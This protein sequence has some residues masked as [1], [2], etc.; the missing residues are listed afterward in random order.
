MIMD[1]ISKIID[2]IRADSDAEAEA[3]L[4]EGKARAAAITE[5]FA[6]LERRAYGDLITKGATESVARFERLKNIAALD[7]KKA[8]L[9]E[10]QELLS[11]AFAA[12]EAELAKLPEAQYTDLLARLAADAA[13]TGAETLVFN[14]ADRARVGAA[15]VDG[16]KKLLAAQGRNASLTLSAETRDIS[17]GVIVSGGDIETNASL[18]ALVALYKNE[19]SPRVAAILFE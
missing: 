16:A 8:V 17:G 18:S 1:G 6:E 13:R 9:T 11:A 7:T 14:A 3:V 12:A 5:E 4:A 2:R 15:V 19:L 10:K